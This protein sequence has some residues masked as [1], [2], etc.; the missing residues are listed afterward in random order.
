MIERTLLQK[1]ENRI[2]YKKALILLGPRQ[3]GK[4]TLAKALAA[5]LHQP[6]EYFNGDSSVTRSLWS[7]DNIEALQQSFGSKKIVIL[8]EAQQIEQVGLICKQ[9]IDADKGI[10]LVLTGSSS[11]EIADKTQEPLTGR[12]WE[13][14]LYPLSSAELMNHQGI[15]TFLQNLPQ[16]LVYGMYPEVATHLQDAKEILTN[17]ASSYLYKD[18]LSL[19]GL[20][21]PILLEKILKALAL[22]LGSEVSLN[23]LANL[24]SADVKTVD[25]YI[26]L[27]EQVFVVFRMG[28][29]SRNERNE[30]STKKKIYFYDNG[31][32]NA[33]MG[34]FAVLPGRDDVGALWENFLIS[35][36]RK[37]LDYHGFYGKTY[38]WR[39]K[40]QAEIDFVEEIDG[41]VYAYE[42]KWNPKA[43]VKF[44]SAFLESYKPAETKVIH[45]ENFWQWLSVYP[46]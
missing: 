13:Y 29:I 9:L 24:V 44:P 27:L 4:T 20:K 17:I 39:N 36:R 35:E 41:K 34:N 16:Y 6:F 40:L 21:K 46:Y 18:V 3:T 32:R 11:L 37:L 30:I 8:D 33:I 25:H 2:D 1:L 23:E 5:K 22:Q 43:K 14:R 7:V 42:F 31:I 15:P 28:T 12:K 45:P 10:Q 38:F 26:G 19:V